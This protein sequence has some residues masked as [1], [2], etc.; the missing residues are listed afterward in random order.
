M[1]IKLG[2]K[3]KDSLTG[4]EGFVTARCEYMNGCVQYI[5]RPATLKDGSPQNT[6]W[7]DEQQIIPLEGEDE[8]ED[9]A[10]KVPSPQPTGGP[11]NHPDRSDPPGFGA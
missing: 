4:F 9:E 10:E 2:M 7:L 11:Q 1:E 5:I 6:V 3:I 8:G